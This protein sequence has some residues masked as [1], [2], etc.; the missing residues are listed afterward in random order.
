MKRFNDFINEDISKIDQENLDR[1]IEFKTHMENIFKYVKMKVNNDFADLI[2]DKHSI[3]VYGTLDHED[4][5]LEFSSKTKL[6]NKVKDWHKGEEYFDPIDDAKNEVSLVLNV[7][8]ELNL[9]AAV[10]DFG[11][12]THFRID[13]INSYFKENEKLLN[14]LKTI[15]KYDL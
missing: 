9:I 1:E 10:G 6:A 5:T 13:L 4:T 15:K 8:N 3:N 2:N 7:L 11:E 12:S 14:S